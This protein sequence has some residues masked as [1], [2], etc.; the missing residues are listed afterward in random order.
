MDGAHLAGS[1]ARLPGQPGGTLRVHSSS[2]TKRQVQQPI[3]APQV[4]KLLH[5]LSQIAGERDLHIKGS[6]S[7]NSFTLFTCREPHL[8]IRTPQS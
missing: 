1:S 4:R 7:Y 6:C 2:S 8:Y 3:I 5:Y